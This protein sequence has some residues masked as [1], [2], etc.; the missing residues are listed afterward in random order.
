M[1]NRPIFEIDNAINFDSTINQ[2][3]NYLSIE[4]TNPTKENM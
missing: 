4:G 2:S 1:L 3:I